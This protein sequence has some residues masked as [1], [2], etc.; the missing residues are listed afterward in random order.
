MRFVVELK[1]YGFPFV[2]GIS[3]IQH[4]CHH[5]I[6]MYSTI[7]TQ[8]FSEITYMCMCMCI[9]MASKNI[10]LKQEAYDRLKALQNEGESFSEEI[11]RLTKNYETDLSD[12]IGL[13]IDISWEQI[14][15]DRN[16]SMEVS[17]DDLLS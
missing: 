7:L 6:Q 1:L 9:N 11:L 15:E 12:I 4:T 3:Y 13:D 14:L 17:R 16:K 8:T 10:S 5:S 2:P